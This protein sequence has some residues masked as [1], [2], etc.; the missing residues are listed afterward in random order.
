MIESVIKI[1]EYSYTLTK[2]YLTTI[3]VEPGFLWEFVLLSIKTCS[4]Y[5]EK[6]FI[7]K[8][9]VISSQVLNNLFSASDIVEAVRGRFCFY[10]YECKVAWYKLDCCEVCR[11][12]IKK[13]SITITVKKKTA[14][15]RWFLV[16]SIVIGAKPL[17]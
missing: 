15:G 17:F 8:F 16:F 5:H 6:L 3:P 14:K 7:Q 10:K 1:L 12:R 11:L 2:Q 13:T 4:L 9:K